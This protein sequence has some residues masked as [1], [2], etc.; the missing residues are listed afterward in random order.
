MQNIK[1][2]TRNSY[3][4]ISELNRAVTPIAVS[5]VFMI[6]QRP[7][8]E[9]R[10]SLYRCP[11]CARAGA[12]ARGASGRAPRTPDDHKHD[13]S[14]LFVP[15]NVPP[16][17]RVRCAAVCLGRPP[18]DGGR[19]GWILAG[20][21]FAGP[22]PVFSGNRITG[23]SNVLLRMVDISSPSRPLPTRQSALSRPDWRPVLRTRT[24]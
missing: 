1:F 7:H 20:V 10:S 17:P 5:P 18:P 15:I 22:S 8:S 4:A 13:E 3:I 14:F 11:V 23:S 6:A 19:R 16:G 2:S 21:V 24:R 12:G 9:P